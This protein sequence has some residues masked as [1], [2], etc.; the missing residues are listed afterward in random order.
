MKAA[1]YAGS[2]GLAAQQEA[3]NVIGNNIANV[4]TNGFQASNVSFESLLSGE[5][6]V[7]SADEPITGYGVRAIN[8][9][10]RMGGG[11][12]KNTNNRM[13]FAI[14]GNGLFAI[15]NNGQIQYTRD[16]TFGITM[17]DDE[18]YLSTQ[19]GKYVLDEDQERIE[20]EWNDEKGGYDM[21]LLTENI[22]VFQFAYPSAMSQVSGNRF[23]PTERSGD[24]IESE[25]EDKNILQGA[26]E[27]S[28]TVM[29]DEMAN[30]IS[31]QRAFQLSARVVQM[32]DENEQ[33]INGL[34]K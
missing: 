15:E 13:D 9:G 21:D 8:T 6:Y 16:G 28:G 18:A 22:G 5:M 25:P 10:V 30:M 32:A 20:L 1:F 34:R 4:N 31:V 19:D 17:D 27:G 14:V 3:M 24:A 33:T 12:L 2:T 23:V 26:L 11:A 7:N 29:E